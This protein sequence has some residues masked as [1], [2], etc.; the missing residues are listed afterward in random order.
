MR[1]SVG[2]RDYESYEEYVRW[3]KERKKKWLEILG[4][5]KKTSSENK[6]DYETTYNELVNLY[7]NEL[8]E[9]AQEL[10]LDPSGTKAELADKIAK[11]LVG[12]ST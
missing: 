12:V 1:Y 2:L 8:V 10:G 6:V 4:I 11:Y 5:S 7:K 9:K 3:R